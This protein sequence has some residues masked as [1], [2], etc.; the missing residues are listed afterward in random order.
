MSEITFLASSKPLKIPEEIQ[1]YNQRTGFENEKDYMF[2]S[3]HEVT[4]GWLQ[5]IRGLLSLPYIY[6]AEGGGNRL[7]LTYLEKYIETGEVL[8]IYSVP[9]QHALLSYKKKV[10]EKP[11][12]IEVNMGSYTY[13]DLSGLYQLNSKKW[14]EELSHRNYI[15]QHGVTTFVKY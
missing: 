14:V 15:T 11:E 7:F 3:V 12:P 13:R 6:E 10:Q 8:E 4:E 5:E 9:N 2:F 1:E